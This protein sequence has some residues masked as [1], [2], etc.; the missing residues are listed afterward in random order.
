MKII[1]LISGGDSGG[2]K[3][4][5]FSLLQ[6]LNT[7]IQA[8]MV[9]FT[10]GVFAQEARE[11]GLNVTVLPGRNLVSVLNKLK[12]QTGTSEEKYAAAQKQFE[13]FRKDAIVRKK[14]VENADDRKEY[15]NWLFKQEQEFEAICMMSVNSNGDL[16]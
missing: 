9:C 12:K 14:L 1:H 3:T 8:D 10:E 4:H 15:Q 11:L 16:R 2:A 13:V 6:G 7:T 5:V